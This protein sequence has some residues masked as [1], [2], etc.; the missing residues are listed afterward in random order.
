MNRMPRRLSTTTVQGAAIT[1][2]LLTGLLAAGCD[3]KPATNVAPTSSALTAAKP[4]AMG[5][6]KF[7]V[8]RESSK[9]EFLMDAPQEKIRGKAYKSTTGDLQIDMDDITKSTGLVTIDIKDLEILQTKADDTGKFGD[10]TRNETQNKHARTWLEISDD[11]PEDVR[12][13][14]SKVQ[15][16]IKSI[17]AKGEKSVLAMP[18]NERTLTL[19]ASGD[20][21]LHGHKAPKTAEL[22]VTFHFEG[23]KPTSVMVKTV[24]PIPVDLAEFE[25]KPRDA[26]GKLAAKTL[27]V[28]APKVNKEAPVTLDFTAKVAG[29]APA[30]PAKAP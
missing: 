22:L 8:D 20:F 25:V 30:A 14:N 4:A 11:T 21:L 26:F 28:L 16:S 2:L 23:S 3:D 17:D 18:G 7:S 27:D 19:T 10:E 12:A 29:S 15:F 5:A 1:G 24:K 9:V 6:L 13:Q